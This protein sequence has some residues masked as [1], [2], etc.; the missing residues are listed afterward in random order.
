MRG[1][2]QV[3]L[4]HIEE[5]PFDPVE[6]DRDVC[7]TIKERMYDTAK[8]DRKGRLLSSISLHC[9]ANA[10]SLLDEVDGLADQALAFSHSIASA[11][12]NTQAAGS[13]GRS[14]SSGCAP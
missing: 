10:C 13:N 9:E 11:K 1:T 2:H 3:Y 4:A 6:F 12:V 14:F 7:T 5:I 8:T